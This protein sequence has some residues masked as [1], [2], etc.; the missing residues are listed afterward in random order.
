MK[1]PSAKYASLD[2][3]YFKDYAKKAF[4]VSEENINLLTMRKL[5]YP[6]QI[7]HSLSGYQAK[8]SQEELI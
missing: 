2:A 7:L 8:S 5:I 4:G 1:T 6:R 3:K